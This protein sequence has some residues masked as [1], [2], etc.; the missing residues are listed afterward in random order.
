[1][2]TVEFRDKENLMQR[3]AAIERRVQNITQ[4]NTMAGLL[5]NN[6]KKWL[7]NS[8]MSPVKLTQELDTNNDGVISGDEFATLLGKMTGERPPEWVVELV[9]SFVNANVNDGI[10]VRDW[11]A[12]LAASGM[13]FPDELFEEKVEVTGSIAILE[14]AFEIGQPVSVTVSFNVEVVAYEF[15]VSNNSTKQ[16]VHSSLIPS[17]DMDRAD[18]DEFTIELDE[19][20][21]YTAEL[22]HLGVRLDTHT[23]VVSAAPEE[24]V[25]EHVEEAAAPVEVDEAPAET[26]VDGL[27]AF[28]GHVET[29]KLR[30][31][32]HAIIKSSSTY[33]VIITVQSISRTLL[34]LNEYRNGY[35]ALC[36][37]DGGTSFRMM[38]KPTE[39]PPAVG[40]TYETLVKPHDWDIALKQL[41]CLEV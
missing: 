38:L 23:F 16:E 29:M 14:D 9:F 30:S 21:T 13:E 4:S 22:R 2:A 10:P 7:S 33:G 3:A 5:N 28:V 35:T 34:G 8:A 31:E 15:L 36:T 12:F 19:P 17:A 25:I 39:N 27:E 11:M 24:P 6:F 18:F 40:Q 1:M 26:V 20:G 37:S 32:A 41:V